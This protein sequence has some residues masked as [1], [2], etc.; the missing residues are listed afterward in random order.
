LSTLKA[1]LVVGSGGFVG[2]ALRFLVGTWTHGMFSTIAFPIGT[3]VVNVTGCLAIGVLGGLAER[4]LLGL[5]AR[6]FLLVG[7]LGGYTT[8]SSFAYETLAL[9]RTSD[10]SAAFANVA[11][12]TVLGLALAWLGYGLVR[13]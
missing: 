2:S 12:Q 8:F 6:L 13:P 3:F 9:A 1:V 7:V 5:D 4:N 11:L 10:L